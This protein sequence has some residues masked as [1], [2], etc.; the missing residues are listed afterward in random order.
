M[1]P[2]NNETNF[3]LI[4]PKFF[5]LDEFVN[6]FVWEKA[7]IGKYK[8]A[9]LNLDNRQFILASWLYRKRK[10]FNRSYLGIDNYVDPSTIEPNRMLLINGT[11]NYVYNLNR[12]D[13]SKATILKSLEVL[14]NW[15][16]RTTIKSPTTL[17]E[18]QRIYRDFTSYLQ[19]I[20]KK[21]EPKKAN[22]KLDLDSFGQSQA[23][24]VQ[25]AVLGMFSVA[26]NN[27][28]SKIERM[29]PRIPR[30]VQNNQDNEIDKHNLDEAL[31][32]CFQFFEQ[33]ADF[34]LNN[35]PYPHKIKL[36]EHEALLV[37]EYDRQISIITPYTGDGRSKKGRYWDFD[38][39][40]LRSE[41]EVREDTI[42]SKE[43]HELKV[44]N[45]KEFMI[46]S[47]L[48]ARQNKLNTLLE[49]NNKKNHKYRLNLG[50]RA[51]KAY[52]LVLLDI[53]AMNDS[54]LATIKW[55]FDDFDE[56]VADSVKLR[57]IKPRAGNK[58]IVFT[59]QSIFLG[60]FR[61]FL[62]LRRFILNGHNCETLFFKGFGTN[63]SLKNY[64]STGGYGKEAYGALKPLYPK[65]KFFGSRTQRLHSKGWAMKKTKGQTFLAAAWLQHTPQVSDLYYPSESRAE[66]QDQIGNYLIYQHAVTMEV[67][68]EQL[69]SSGACTSVS[70]LPKAYS[71]SLSIKP[72]CQKKMTCLFCTH[73][74]IKPISEEIHKLLSMK[75]VIDR[76]SILHAR[77][78][79]QFDNI[80]GPI[81]KRIKLLFETMKNKYPKTNDI[82][83]ELRYKVYEEQCLHWYWEKK[84]EQLWELGWV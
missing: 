30:V 13:S 15:L 43:Y 38:K 76:H 77:S 82:I 20:I 33:V 59:I 80:M 27:K 36:L 64:N 63:A 18:A 51:M 26:F 68:D 58:D 7:D 11:I 34:C 83:A 44:K 48:K 3:I 70:P 19:Q 37:P 57:N 73:Y 25:S 54:T 56:L 52:F 53:T 4:V 41:I 32:Y 35:K 22:S 42:K 50:L 17:E 75:Y 21:H 72:D 1:K 10:R 78:Q 8:N 45:E 5:T 60:S 71:D 28:P 65:L 16:N 55:N 31:S 47:R 81:L 24:K 62:K 40:I 2:L 61:T 12:L 46:K 9:A 39:G 79:E 66:S 49:A 74:R 67:T 29:T 84:L 69:S 6:K 23:H 14:I